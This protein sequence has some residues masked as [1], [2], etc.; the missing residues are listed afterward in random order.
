MKKLEKN[1]QKKGKAI[2]FIKI[3]KILPH[4]TKII[5]YIEVVL[6][7]CL[8]LFPSIIL[9][10][11]IEIFEKISLDNLELKHIML[12]LIFIVCLLVINSI[13]DYLYCK[14]SYKFG[15]EVRN[16]FNKQMFEKMR[17]IDLIELEDP[18][19]YD[20][21]NRIRDTMSSEFIGYI[22]GFFLI[23]KNIFVSFSVSVV[24]WQLHWSFPIIIIIGTIPYVFFFKKLNFNHYFTI[25]DNSTKTRKNHYIIR[26]LT[27]REFANEIKTYNLFDYLYDRHK[28]MRNELFD[29]TYSLVKKYTFYA[30][31]LS[32][33][34]RVLH[35]TCLIICI[36][37]ILIG[38][39]PVGYFVILIESLST[40]QSAFSNIIMKYKDMDRNLYVLNDYLD[41]NHLSNEKISYDCVDLK[42]KDIEINNISFDYPS[43]NDVLKNINLKIPFGQKIAI[44]G[45]NGSGKS[46]L[47]SLLMG[48]YSPKLGNVYIGGIEIEKCKSLFRNKTSFLFQNFI[49]FKGTIKDNIVFGNNKI[50]DNEIEQVFYELDNGEFLSKMPKGIYTNVGFLEENSIEISGGEWQKIAFVRALINK[51][52]DF[53]ILDEFASALDA[54]TEANIY[55]K[56]NKLLNNKTVISISH[57]MGITKNVDRIVVLNDGKI[58]EDGTHNELMKNK[59]YYYKMYISQ[60]KLYE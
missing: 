34:K 15:Y 13:V 59:S 35:L 52:I 5:F 31:I 26:L 54:K 12:I 25:M 50:S 36:Y 14:F 40:L 19:F 42:N 23:I 27:G 3:F 21:L 51:E 49:K 44:V 32:L 46:T 1:K 4:K 39:R 18:N 16:I 24:I 47:M 30:A 56:M 9:D 2:Q 20:V 43:Y 10:Y 57:R 48:V 17:R 38:K 11:E 7:L 53:I 8:S 22:T 60:R 33:F 45:E 28:V 6:L 41:F 55:E 58:V 37:L 29:E